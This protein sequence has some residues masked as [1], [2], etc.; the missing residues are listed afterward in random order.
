VK[1][2]TQ[3]SAYNRSRQQGA[4]NFEQN[5]QSF[6][7]ESFSRGELYLKKY[8]LKAKAENNKEQIVRALLSLADVNML[9]VRKVAAIQYY[10]LAWLEAQD[11]AADH[12]LVI[13]FDQPVEL[14]SF[15]Y[16]HKLREIK[17]RDESVDVPLIFNVQKTGRETKVEAQSES[18]AQGVVFKR[19]RRAARRLVFRPAFEQ[20]KMVDTLG[21][22]H[23][24]RVLVKKESEG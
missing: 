2:E 12:E 22:Q 17:R 7:I 1:S 4:A 16:A 5:S 3:P 6:L 20:G 10:Q 8:L 24:V 11:L 13:A 18:Q 21:Y 23:N 14:P 15:N 19:A 9:F